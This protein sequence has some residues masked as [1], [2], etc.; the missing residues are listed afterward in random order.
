VGERQ[1][2]ILA[3]GPEAQVDPRGFERAVIRAKER[4]CA[5]YGLDL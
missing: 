5:D 3:I 4:A 1:F 2:V